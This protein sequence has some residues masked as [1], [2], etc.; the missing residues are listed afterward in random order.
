MGHF[1]TKSVFSGFMRI[2]YTLFFKDFKGIK[3]KFI[4][5]LLIKDRDQVEKII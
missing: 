4:N 5:L 1:L 3:N 2:M